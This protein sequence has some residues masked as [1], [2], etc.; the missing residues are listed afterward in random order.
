MTKM[1]TQNPNRREFLKKGL[2]VGL[3]TLASITGAKYAA[4]AGESVQAADNKLNLETRIQSDNSEKEINK[5]LGSNYKEAFGD[6]VH[7]QVPEYVSCSVEI[8]SRSET[9]DDNPKSVKDYRI[10]FYVSQARQVLGNSE[11][12]IE[13]LTF[14]PV[15]FFDIEGDNIKISEK[16]ITAQKLGNHIGDIKKKPQLANIAFDNANF[17]SWEMYYIENGKPSGLSQEIN[18]ISLPVPMSPEMKECA[19]KVINSNGAFKLRG[20]LRG[21]VP[22]T[23]FFDIY[24]KEYSDLESLMKLQTGGEGFGERLSRYTNTMKRNIGFY[25]SIQSELKEEGKKALEQ[26]LDPLQILNSVKVFTLSI[27]DLLKLDNQN[28]LSGLITKTDDGLYQIMQPQEVS[29]RVNE[30]TSEHKDDINKQLKIDTE[31][32]AVIKAIPVKGKGNFDKHDIENHEDKYTWK[33]DSSEKMYIAKNVQLYV[34]DS[35][36]KSITQRIS[37]LSEILGLPVNF[38]CEMPLVYNP[39]KNIGIFKPEWARRKMENAKHHAFIDIEGGG[40]RLKE[41]SYEFGAYDPKDIVQAELVFRDIRAPKRVI[42]RKSIGGIGFFHEEWTSYTGINKGLRHGKISSEKPNMHN[43][44]L[45][46]IQNH[47]IYVPSIYLPDNKA[48]EPLQIPE[49]KRDAP[50]DF[51]LYLQVKQHLDD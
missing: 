28:K 47:A 16:R 7:L 50:I 19:K 49:S 36:F 4:L 8:M 37:G 17:I 11:T 27:E 15:Y 3:V 21:R 12:L 44:R 9:I 25:A 41:W 29:K 40:Y 33:G 30:I 32:E 34:L 31:A 14:T 42:D 1:N 6:N 23:L 46:I 22:E 24:Q 38:Y 39:G 26:M 20:K 45:K 51:D 10:N 5:N 18:D 43:E 35:S 13:Q 2:K 48:W